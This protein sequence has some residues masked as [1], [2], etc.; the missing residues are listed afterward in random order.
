MLVW[1]KDLQSNWLSWLAVALTMVV[2]SAACALAVSMLVATSDADDDP[3][4]PLGG[5][6]LGMAVCAVVLI[7][8]SQMRLIIEEREPVYRSWRMIGMPGWMINSF[9][10]GQVSAV[11]AI[12]ALIGTFPARLFVEPM[13]AAFRS[14]GIPMP[15]LAITPLVIRI[16]VSV[17]VA[18]AV[19]GALIPLRRVFRPRVESR[20]V[21]VVLRCLV[22][23]GLVG[24]A[25]YGCLQIEDP[26]DSL[27]ASMGLVILVALMTP[28]LM[29][30]LDQWT[31]L[32]G[33]AGA[34]VRVR[35]RFSVPHIVPWVLL[36]GLIVAVGSGVMMLKG[37]ESL[38]T[39]SS[40]RV[41]AAFLGPVVAPSIVGAVL[42][43][44]IMRS[45][46]ASDVR[47]LRLAGASPAAWARVQV[48]EAFCLTVTAAAIVIALS[49]T[50]V[51]LLN[52]LLHPDSHSGMGA[53]WEG[54]AGVWW[55]PFGLI[56]G[57]MF[58]AL[59][60]VK[61]ILAGFLRSTAQIRTN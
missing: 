48:G 23:A 55:A 31:R 16:A 7:T 8:L 10:V 13:A 24:G 6:V 59:C 4:G 3:T 15:E 14:D 58:L 60:A 43:S 49:A 53:L 30:A 26:G 9:I 57:A 36:G 5:T 41:F 45:R 18:S 34:N 32:C 46:I 19:C 12:A 29:P 51:M 21:W 35:R 38:D 52:Q 28:W 44:L 17:C 61:L 33:I 56:F 22:A 20:P 2:S 40:G 47:G 25:V 39:L 42:T 50:V 1:L 37:T 11:S 27:A 54:L